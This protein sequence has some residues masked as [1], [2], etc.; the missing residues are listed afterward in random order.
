MS[1]SSSGALRLFTE[2]RRHICVLIC[3]CDLFENRVQSVFIILVRTVFVR[4]CLMFRAIFNS[5]RARV[6]AEA[7]SRSEPQR[8]LP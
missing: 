5:G 1:R 8:A 4:A 2:L 3:C 6:E 7:T